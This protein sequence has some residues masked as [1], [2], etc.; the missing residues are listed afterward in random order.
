MP[1]HVGR[2]ATRPSRMAAVPRWV[3]TLLVVASVGALGVPAASAQ[4]SVK[5]SDWEHAGNGTGVRFVSLQTLTEPNADQLTLPDQTNAGTFQYGLAADDVRWADECRCF[6]YYIINVRSSATGGLT[7]HKFKAIPSG[8]FPDQY[9]QITMAITEGDRTDAD[10]IALPVGSAPGLQPHVVEVVLHKP[11]ESVL[12]SGTSGLQVSLT[13][14]GS[15]PVVVSGIF[16]VPEQAD[17]WI[18]PPSVDAVSLP[19][20]LQPQTTQALKVVVKPLTKRAIGVSWPP[21]EATMRHTTFSIGV[22]YENPLLQNRR[23]QTSLSVPIRFQ[24]NVVALATALGAGVLLGSLVLLSRRKVKLWKP[25]L[26]ALAT[27]LLVGIILELVGMFLVAKDSKLV[28]FG[29]NFDPWQS[30]PVVLLGTGVG[31]LGVKSAERLNK[32]FPADKE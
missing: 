14:T 21:T 11:L 24:P 28:V 6:R 26:R 9:A 16:V 27:A 29:F 31:L 32:V 2:Q 19:Q 25:W 3:R 17:L 22:H 4:P 5:L 1:R 8:S 20:T 10:T 13:N 30:L 15:M 12:L 18:E 7:R 23:G